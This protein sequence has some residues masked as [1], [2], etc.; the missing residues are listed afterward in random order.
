MVFINIH[1]LGVALWNRRSGRVL[2]L[3]LLV[4]V[5]AE[6]AFDTYYYIGGLWGEQTQIIHVLSYGT[7][8]F[9]LLCHPTLAIIAKIN[10]WRTLDFLNISWSTVLTERFLVNRL[11]FVNL[12]DRGELSFCSN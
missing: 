7:F 1:H 10:A 9:K 5:I 4:F 6:L 12:S 11:Q 2:A 3:F 8:I